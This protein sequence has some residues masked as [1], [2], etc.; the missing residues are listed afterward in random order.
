MAAKDSLAQTQNVVSCLN[1]QLAT[2]KF[3][4]ASFQN[5]SMEI[6]GMMRE[7]ILSTR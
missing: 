5:L 3:E 6:Q 7:E 4:Y 1:S 2:L